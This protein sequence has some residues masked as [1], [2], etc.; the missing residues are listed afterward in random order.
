M[1]N[2]VNIDDFKASWR[3]AYSLVG[4]WTT[5][6]VFVNDR[7]GEAELVQM[8]DEGEAIRTSLSAVDALLLSTVLTKKVVK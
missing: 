6:R 1:G 7:T 3:E 5:L 4:E 2:V 8:N